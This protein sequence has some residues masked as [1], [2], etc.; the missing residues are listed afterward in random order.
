MAT[1]IS[2]SDPIPLFRP[3]KK[4]KIYRQRNQDDENE[5]KPEISTNAPAPTAAAIPTEQSLDE[6]IASNSIPIKKEE[7]DGEAGMEETPLNISEILRLRKQRKKIGG[8]EFKAESKIRDG[9]DDE[10]NG[11]ALVKYEDKDA[12]ETQPEGGL[13]MRRFAPQMG[14]VGSGVDKHMMAYIESKLGHTSQS[15]DSPFTNP[16]AGIPKNEISTTQSKESQRAPT[17][18]GQILEIDLGEES[19]ARNAYRTEMARRKAAGE[20]IELEESTQTTSKP[21]LGRDG[22]PWRGRK[23]RG[24]DDVQRDALVDAILHENRLDI[25][26]PVPSSKEMN[27]T[28]GLANDE[29]VAESFRKDWE[30]A[31]SHASLQR[32][33]QIS[34]KAAKDKK[35]GAQDKTEEELYM[36]GPKLGG[37]RSAR[38]A[39][40][41]SMLKGKA[42]KR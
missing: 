2:N 12:E 25:Y 24:S 4:R 31:S 20:V 17:T 35:K 19:R 38:A 41:E 9:N 1:P 30:E 5:I 27:H 23:R 32:Q 29:M 34:E 10:E 3:S 22:K 8:V 42:V 21:R 11:D 26:E 13:S 15:V 18:M 6:L 37:S 36:K 14:V 28:T 33:Q 7:E 39:M 16:Q 40:R